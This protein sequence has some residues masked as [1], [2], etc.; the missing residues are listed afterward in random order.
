MN[1][2]TTDNTAT[3]AQRCLGQICGLVNRLGFKQAD[4]GFG[5]FLATELDSTSVE[6]L[7]CQEPNQTIDIT[8]SGGGDSRSEATI[9]GIGEFLERYSMYWPIE[10]TLRGTRSELE[11]SGRQAV[12]YEYL[13]IWSEVDL[14]DAGLG[15][16][17]IETEIEW[18]NGVNL[19]SGQDIWLPTELISFDVARDS[20]RYFPSTTSGN[21]CE[22]SLA[23][24]LLNSVYEQIER[25]AI[26]RTWFEQRVP[27]RLDIS[28]WGDLEAIRQ[29]IESGTHRLD[30]LDL[31][32]PTECSVV[33][34]V[35][36]NNLGKI[37]KFL[38]FAGAHLTVQG[39][40]RAALSETAEGLIQMKYRL[41]GNRVDRGRDIDISSVYNFVDNVDYYMDP[42]H[43]DLVDHLLDGDI[44]QVSSS[45]RSP[46]EQKEAELKSV[47]DGLVECNAT[48]I[49]IELTPPDV[50]DLGF[51]TSYVFVPQL[52]DIS[53]PALPPV[54]HPQMQGMETELAHPFP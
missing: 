37:P 29:R 41:S 38:T 25:D 10:T 19:V 22:N 27:P 16:Y 52:I 13:Q 47:L 7:I 15:V 21:A 53:L 39:A 30:L 2:S 36:T 51:H 43:F 50:R 11:S 14:R 35:Y 24:A 1:I 31:Q 46:P 9:R 8:A 54:N 5:D 28:E 48:P 6:R 40:V 20:K 23:G 49:G 34:A 32:T 17:D 44:V 4:R 33:M 3:R 18:A 12:D 26:M 45:V 42:E